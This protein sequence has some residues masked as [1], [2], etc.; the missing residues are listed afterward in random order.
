MEGPRTGT[1]MKRQN[2]M[3]ASA[4]ALLAVFVLAVLTY[5]Q[6]RQQR[7]LEELARQPTSLFQRAH[8]P[9]YGPPDAKVKITEFFDPACETCS[10]FYP[11]VKDL[12]DRQSGKVQL[13]E[14]PGQYGLGSDLRGSRYAISDGHLVRVDP[15]SLEVQ[16][17]LRNNIGSPD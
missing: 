5:T 6:W 12:V 16:S 17:V 10:A 15:N 2:I 9:T 7:E 1:P 13:I 8:S 14:R 11:I 3:L 4:A